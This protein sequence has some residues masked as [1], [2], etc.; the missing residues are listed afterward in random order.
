MAEWFVNFQLADGLF[1]QIFSE[2][3]NRTGGISAGPDF[4][5]SEN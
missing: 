2:L 3:L 1:I 4:Q 5:G